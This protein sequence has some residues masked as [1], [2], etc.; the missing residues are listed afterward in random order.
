MNYMLYFMHSPLSIYALVAIGILFE[1]VSWRRK[2]GIS[3]L[4][5]GVL[6]RLSEWLLISFRVVVC[7]TLHAS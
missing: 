2:S 3:V 7:K 5:F 1:P 4:Q 6:V